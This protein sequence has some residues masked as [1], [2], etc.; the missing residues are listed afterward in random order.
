MSR[1]LPGGPLPDDL[2]VA[3]EAVRPALRLPL[4]VSW[5]PAVTSTMD[6][7]SAAAVAGAD[8]GL[9]LVADEQTAGR[10]RRGRAWSSPPGAGLY[11]SLLLRPPLP[12][13][14]TLALLTLAAGVGVA[15]GVREATGLAPGLKWPNDLM[16]ARRKLAGILAE[17]IGM[18]APGQAVVLGIGVNVQPAAYPPDVE[19][20]ATSLEGELGR[21]IDRGLL[22]AAILHGVSDRYVDLMAGRAGD[23]LQAWRAAAPR[24]VGAAVEWDTPAGARTGV[25]AGVDDTGALLV[26]TSAGVERIIAGEVRWVN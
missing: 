19:A 1:R 6:L 21:A 22:L 10:G 14:D 26:R 12:V 18:G 20:R 24:A 4:A 17:G 15:A 2:A 16:I 8:E 11:L 5:L 3:L 23:I 25:T 13:G 9:V 7:V